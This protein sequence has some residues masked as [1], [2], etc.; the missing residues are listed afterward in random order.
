[1][2]EKKYTLDDLV[3]VIKILRGENGC[4]W[5]R[6]QTHESIRMD[7]LEEAYEAADAID[8]GDM[9]NLKEELGDVLMQVVFHAEIEAEKGGFT[10][11]DVIRGICEK[12]IYRHPHVFGNGDVKVDTAEQVLVN[13]E[14]LKKKEKHTETQTEVMKNVPDALPALIRAR[15]VQKKAADVGFDFPVTEDALKKVYEE[16]QELEEAARA[17]NGNIE[18]EFGDILFALVNIS[19]FLKINPEFAL[20]KAIKKFINRFEYIEKSALLQGKDLS[21]MTLEEMDLLWDEAKIK[22]RSMKS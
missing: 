12:M 19:R 14:E 21:G 18:E 6:V 15:K 16:V 11:E 4:P 2:E 9:E 8:K 5:D 7:M 1:M 17:E 20:T 13:W 10:I 3:Q 22:L